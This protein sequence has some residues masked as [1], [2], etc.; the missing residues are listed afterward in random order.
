[1]GASGAI[2]AGTMG[3]S[4]VSAYMESESIKAKGKHD[5][6]VAEQ[7]ARFAEL[8]GEDAIKRGDKDAARVKQASKAMA[9]SQRASLAAQGVAVDTGSAAEVQEETQ[10]LGALDALT[11]K[12]NAWREAWGLKVQADNY[13]SQA[14]MAEM[15]SNR[16]V[17]NTL[18]TGGINAAAS[19]ASIYSRENFRGGSDGE[20][21]MRIGRQVGQGYNTRAGRTA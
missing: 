10:V 16:A 1:M 21:S 20:G 11:V 9:G 8:Q 6:M 14:R 13:R 17:Q 5:R 19:M 18:L 12:N 4:A 2:S 3:L 15:G 7:N